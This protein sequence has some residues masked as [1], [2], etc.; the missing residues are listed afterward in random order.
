MFKVGISLGTDIY[1]GTSDFL[2]L[3]SLTKLA[4]IEIPTLNTTYMYIIYGATQ[5]VAS[6][7]SFSELYLI[8]LQTAQ[9]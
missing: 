4:P 2:G 6:F 5:H 1:G 3:L 8:V 7:D 9:N